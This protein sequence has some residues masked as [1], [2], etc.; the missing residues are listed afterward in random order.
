M[1]DTT[2]LTEAE[3]ITQ[4]KRYFTGVD[5]EDFETIAS[6]MVDGCLFTVET[7]G[8]RLVGLQEIKAMFERLWTNHAAVRHY[9]FVYVPAP[10]WNQI[11]T[12]F[13]VL[14]THHD[15]SETRKSNCNFFELRGR[16]FSHIAVYMA[17]ENTLDKD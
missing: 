17:G 8:V 7:H 12:R 2:V 13:Q 5:A 1:T 10:D 15:G 11:A 3:M 4:V 16:H 14:N 6:T 9:D